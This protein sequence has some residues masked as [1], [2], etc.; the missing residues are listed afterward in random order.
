MKNSKEKQIMFNWLNGK[1][2]KT[3]KRET[4]FLTVFYYNALTVNMDEI[5]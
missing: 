5:K 1:A 4:I 2:F 3:L